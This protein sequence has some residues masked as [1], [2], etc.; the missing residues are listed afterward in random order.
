MPNLPSTLGQSTK[1]RRG[2]AICADKSL[3]TSTL[4]CRLFRVWF[5]VPPR[6]PKA[7]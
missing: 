5:R 1:V 4:F 3:V 6:I 7:L 2:A